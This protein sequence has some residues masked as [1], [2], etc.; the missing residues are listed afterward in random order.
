LNDTQILTIALASAPAP[1]A[2]LLG[3]L[4]NNA[5][6]NDFREHLDA[7]FD[8]REERWRSQNLKR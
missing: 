5:L 2:V 8:Q 3:I 4:A 1:V 7:R 6:L